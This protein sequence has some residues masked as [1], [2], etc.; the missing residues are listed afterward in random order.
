MKNVKLLLIIIFLLLG[1]LKW[2]A[3]EKVE[4]KEVTSY[5]IENRSTVVPFTSVLEGNTRDILKFCSILSQVS[6]QNA[7]MKNYLQVIP[8]VCFKFTRHVKIKT[9][10][11]KLPPF[12]ERKILYLRI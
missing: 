12:I 7:L 11:L 8:V 2:K 5:S 10:I 4:K 3:V 6:L 1:G 9:E